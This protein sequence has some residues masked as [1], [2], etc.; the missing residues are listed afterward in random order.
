MLSQ[1]GQITEKLTQVSHKCV[2]SRKD[3]GNSLMF[4]EEQ[5][6]ILLKCFWVTR[7]VIFTVTTQPRR[8]VYFYYIFFFP[9]VVLYFKTNIVQVNP[10]KCEVE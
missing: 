1:K 9:P 5:F 7:K 4:T 8:N 10:E 6:E 2:W 3:D